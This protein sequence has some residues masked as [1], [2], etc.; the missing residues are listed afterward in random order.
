M[1]GVIRHYN[2]AIFFIFVTSF[3]MSFFVRCK[4][5]ILKKIY[6]EMQFVTLLSCFISFLY[7]M[8][9]CAR[10]GPTYFARIDILNTLI[11][12][13]LLIFINA[14]AFLIRNFLFL[15]FLVFFSLFYYIFKFISPSVPYKFSTK[16][17]INP[18]VVREINLN[19]INNI[20]FADMLGLKEVSINVPKSNIP[21]NWLHD[22]KM[23]MGLSELFFKYGLVSR[24]LII[25]FVPD[26]SINIKYSL[27]DYDKI[28]K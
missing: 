11:F 9:L 14:L 4:N 6:K 15:K 5:K 10:V 1:G 19:I 25:H 27:S 13:I 28:Y 17:E 2:T 22:N 7:L 12:W 18:I 16:F 8:L 23:A 24:K 20:L 26:N 21:N 3:T